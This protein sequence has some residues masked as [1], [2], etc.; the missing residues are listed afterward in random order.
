MV[1]LTPA[2]CT[3]ID[4]Q[5]GSNLLMFLGG[6]TFRVRGSGQL[7]YAWSVMR[8]DDILT[9]CTNPSRIILSQAFSPSVLHNNHHHATTTTTTKGASS[10]LKQTHNRSQ[11][12]LLTVT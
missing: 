8:S 7:T 9:D 12:H 4:V 2:S 6:F 5:G 11:S 1:T 3:G 10:N